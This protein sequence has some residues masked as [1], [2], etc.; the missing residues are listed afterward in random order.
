MSV[1]P[2]K[3]NVPWTSCTTVSAGMI[4]VRLFSYISSSVDVRRQ[5]SSH[6]LPLQFVDNADRVGIVKILSTQAHFPPTPTRLCYNFFLFHALQQITKRQSWKNFEDH[7]DELELIGPN[8]LSGGHPRGRL[9][10]QFMV[11]M[12]HYSLNH[13]LS[14]GK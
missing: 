14:I 1:F 5:K 7:D 12:G 13:M 8:D 10:V 6:A 4:K 3:S 9:V 11:Q 2:N